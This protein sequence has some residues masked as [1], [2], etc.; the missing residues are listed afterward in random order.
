[1]DLRITGGHARGR[2]LKLGVGRGVRPTSSRTREA[3]FSLV[4][5]DLV[6]YR[7]LDAYGGSGLIGLEAWSR[8]A[9]VTIV[10]RHPATFRALQRRGQ[11]L[12]VEWEAILGDI[13][14]V[15]STLEAFDLVFADPP[16][17]YEPGPVLLGLCEHVRGTLVY[18]APKEAHLPTNVGPLELRKQRNYGST[19][20]AVYE[21]CHV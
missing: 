13:L 7:F 18:E 10:E 21:F 6:D 1:M 9:S 20:L 17:R 11:E 4:G 5:H 12:E 14:K 15:V 2:V 19:Q 3:L 8:G 16:Y